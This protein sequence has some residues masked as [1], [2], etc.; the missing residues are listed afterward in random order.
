MDAAQCELHRLPGS[1]LATLAVGAW[2]HL[3]PRHLLAAAAVLMTAT[4]LAVGTSSGFWPLLLIAFVGT[5][6]PTPWC[7]RTS[8]PTSA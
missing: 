1:A 8:R 3:W 5:L 6:N 7:S 4:D 2:G